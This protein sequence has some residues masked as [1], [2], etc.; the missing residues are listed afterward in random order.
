MNGKNIT[1]LVFN[2]AHFIKFN[3]YIAK[4]YSY[5]VAILVAIFIEMEDYFERTPNLKKFLKR[6]DGY[7]FCMHKYIKERNGM[8]E[9]K[10]RRAVNKMIELNLI[11]KKKWS[12]NQNLFKVNHN[13]LSQL[14]IV[15]AAESLESKE[16]KGV[17]IN[18]KMNELLH[19]YDLS[20]NL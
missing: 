11:E 1:E 15:A 7:F 17:D 5:D 18:D 3:E 14:L 6:T 10:M 16:K 12:G 9:D 2:K 8:S 19:L 4:K 20:Q 13:T